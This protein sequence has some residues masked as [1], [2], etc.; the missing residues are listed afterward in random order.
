[1]NGAK[2]RQPRPLYRIGQR[3][4]RW[5]LI[6]PDGSPF[7]SLGVVHTGAVPG[8]RDEACERRIPLTEQIAANLHQWGFNTA[9]YHHPNELRDRMPFLADT[10]IAWVIYSAPRPR[11]PD[12]FGGYGGAVRRAVHQMCAPVKSNPNLI[13]YYWTDTPRW[14]LDTARRLVNDDWVSAIR[15]GQAIYRGKQ[16]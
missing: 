6:A 10:Y 2:T 7:I 16:R 14:D 15:R 13:G 9:G 3:H 1:V 11:Y 4:G 12:V 8:F 5:I